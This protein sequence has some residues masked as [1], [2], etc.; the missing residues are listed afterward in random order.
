MTIRMRCQ[1]KDRLVAY[2]Y[3]EG[4]AGERAA[5]DAHLAECA[6]CASELQ[7]LQGVR[8]HLAEWST[9]EIDLGFRVVREPVPLPRR[10]PW[11]VPAWAALP[12]AAMLLLAVGA[13]L[14]SVELRYDSSG[15]TLRTGW[16]HEPRPA[17]PQPAGPAAAPAALASSVSGSG[18]DWRTALTET[19][20]KLRAELADTRAG[21]PDAGALTGD[22]DATLR[23]V[24]SLIEES[25]RR[26][27]REF[28][29]RLTQFAADV[30]AQRRAD[31]LQIDQNV[32]Q[33]EGLAATQHDM[34]NYIVRVSQG[35]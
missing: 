9:P 28:A 24:R 10:P 12:V 19:E 26:Q 4:D 33:I 5:I 17:A 30:E 21:G 29:L 3:G 20:R 2:L 31:L 18:G 34:M 22:R 25:E 6:A 35:Q 16:N 8:R 27:Q 23:L 11:S 1:D 13:A 7:E 32:D 14:A 15:F